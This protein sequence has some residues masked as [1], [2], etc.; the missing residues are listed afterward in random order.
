ML[1]EVQES[2]GMG[3]AYGWPLKIS[4]KSE[5]VKIGEMAIYRVQREEA[6]KGK[7]ERTEK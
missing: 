1:W 2:L 6:V 7:R 5:S 3:V 4:V